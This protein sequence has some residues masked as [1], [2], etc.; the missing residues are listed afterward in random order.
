MNLNSLKYTPNLQK[1]FD[2]FDEWVGQK[3]IQ[4]PD[5]YLWN[6]LT[7]GVMTA[8]AEYRSAA[9][10]QFMEMQKPTE[11]RDTF[12][13]KIEKWNVTDKIF[14]VIGNN[15]CDTQK[16]SVTINLPVD[17]T[18]SILSWMEAF[19]LLSLKDGKYQANNEVVEDDEEDSKQE[20]PSREINIDFDKYSIYEYL[21]KVNRGDIQLNPDFQRNLVW[22]EE[23]K[24]K[25][26]ESVLM[27][28]PL[29]PIFLKR[30][31]DRKLIV[32]DGLQRT[33]TLKDFMADKFALSGLTTISEL[34]GKHFS[35]MDTV[36]DGYSA[37]FEDCQMYFYV[38]QPSVSMSV[39]YDVFKRINTGG[40][41]LTRQEIRNCIFNGNSTR[42]IKD[43]ADN[44]IFKQSVGWGISYMRMKDREIVLRCLAFVLFD[45][46]KDYNG[47]LDEFLEK[48]MKELNKK[49]T[50][51]IE[52][53]ERIAL[54]VYQKTYEIYGYRNFRVP[55]VYTRG[56]INTAFLES[57]FRVFYYF[58][59]NNIEIDQSVCQNAQDSLLQSEEFLSAVK[60][61]TG[62]K[63]QVQKRFSLAFK[64]FNIEK[65]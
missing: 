35:E 38:M 39:V 55:T 54:Q 45:F 4:T 61:S 26:I 52:K 11:R 13:E 17:A 8:D 9:E 3:V 49:S 62:S 21:R 51:E 65:P 64:Y 46:E 56:R 53:I 27:G 31:S 50:E 41:Q 34:N 1:L 47:S 36:H 10:W 29:P 20:S 37:R 2:T 22:R 14:K 15:A 32:V 23:Q 58:I 19:S 25:F 5:D 16:I 18:A 42:I 24:S 59:V 43:I 12:K 48:T 60:W 44:D 33:S 30:L 28:L 6:L 57:I 40:T 63:S 7:I